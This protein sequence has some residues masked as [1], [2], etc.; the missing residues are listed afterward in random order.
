[1]AAYIVPSAAVCAKPP[2]ELTLC[3]SQVTQRGSGTGDGR[4]FP[5]ERFSVQHLEERRWTA[6]NH[7]LFSPPS[8][9][10]TP[11]HCRGLPGWST[12]PW[13]PLQPST[14]LSS[15]QRGNDI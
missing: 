12:G 5:S 3:T 13:D 7:H 11:P 8:A 10:N 14:V 9:S 15:A 1:M 4:P 6:V 2:P